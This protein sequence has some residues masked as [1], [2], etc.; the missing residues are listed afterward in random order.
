MGHSTSAANTCVGR[1]DALF[2]IKIKF[3]I[4]VVGTPEGYPAL[5]PLIFIRIDSEFGI[6]IHSN[7]HT[8][9]QITSYH[10]TS[11]VSTKHWKSYSTLVR[12][13][14]RPAPELSNG[15]N[16]LLVDV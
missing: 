5:D 2:K 8:S 14:S 16:L 7:H 4:R 11:Q 13:P 9:Q 1:Y 15:P 12:L 6:V 10:K 3:Q